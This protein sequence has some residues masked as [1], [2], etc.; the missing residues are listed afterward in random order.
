MEQSRKPQKINLKIFLRGKEY[1]LPTVEKATQVKDV[2]KALQF[3]SI[4]EA[5][6]KMAVTDRSPHWRNRI[7]RL[8]GKAQVDKARMAAHLP[9]NWINGIISQA[10]YNNPIQVM[11]VI[12]V[13]AC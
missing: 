11:V 6:I 3:S 8:Q 2:G 7:R 4:M 1:L 12:W 10:I 9:R 5:L 13:R